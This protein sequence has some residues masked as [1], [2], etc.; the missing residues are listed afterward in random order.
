MRRKDTVE[1]QVD[2]FINFL[3]IERNLATNTIE[4]YTTDL[5]GYIEYLNSQGINDLNDIGM[6][7]ISKFIVALNKKKLSSFTIARKMSAIRMFHRFLQGENISSSNPADNISFPKLSQRLPL[8]LN[9]TEMEQI[10]E[11]PDIS[12][13]LGLRD[14]A[15]LEFAYATG[16]RVSEIISTRIPDVM[17]DDELVRVVGKGSKMRIIPLGKNAIHFVLKYCYES[18]ELL[19]KPLTDETL[20]LNRSGK[21]LSRMGFW[22]I[23]KKYVLQAGI[24]KPVSPHTIRHSFATH[25]I[26]GGADL[27][28]VQEML[29]HVSISSTQIYTHI[30]REYLKKVHQTYHPRE[31]YYHHAIQSN[32]T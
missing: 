16:T 6:S 28:A 7:D 5:I 18:R 17:I 11:Q 13:V 10:L 22:I 21:R 25:L 26:E 19:K 23:F 1:Q 4:A 3:S 12:S 32:N 24:I 27:R 2:E 31:K 15:M 20:F 30:D 29:G 14:R 9:K 8:V